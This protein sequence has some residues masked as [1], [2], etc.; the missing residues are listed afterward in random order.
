MR[1]LTLALVAVLAFAT[2]ALAK[3]VIPKQFQG[4]W[5]GQ[6]DDDSSYVRTPKPCKIDESTT[7]MIITADK[8]DACKVLM[9]TR[10]RPKTEDYLVRLNCG[11]SAGTELYWL[12]LSDDKLTFGKYRGG[13]YR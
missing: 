8:V 10:Y 9:V 7:S 2:P 12:W 4:N 1:R 5:C 13:G 6:I 11:D 3:N